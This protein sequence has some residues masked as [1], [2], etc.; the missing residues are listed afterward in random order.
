VFFYESRKAMV[1]KSENVRELRMNELQR[2]RFQGPSDDRFALEIVRRA[3]VEQTDEAWSTLQQYFGET[4]K[5]WIRCHPSRDH[6][7][8]YDSEENYIA[9]TFSRFWYAMR[10]QQVEFTTLPAALA[11]LHA[12]LGGVMTDTL[13][14]HSRSREVPFTESEAS[15]ELTVE[16]PLENECLWEGMQKLLYDEHERRLFYLLYSCG[17]KPREIVLHCPQEFAEVQDIYRLNKTIVERLRRNSARL[18]YLWG[19]DE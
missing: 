18:R 14:F 4:I 11:Y 10:S 9:Q 16:E 15:H 13:R 5:V 1:L 19:S 17:L 3:L 7:L 8:Q 2:L 6:A 12:T